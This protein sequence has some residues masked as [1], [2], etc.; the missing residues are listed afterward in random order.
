MASRHEAPS[1]T[2]QVK[3]HQSHQ[4]WKQGLV[5]YCTLQVIARQRNRKHSACCLATSQRVESSRK[6]V[7]AI[8]TQDPEPAA[9]GNRGGPVV[10]VGPCRPLQGRQL[11]KLHAA[12]SAMHNVKQARVSRQ[13]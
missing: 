6:D 3:C 9:V 2:T 4:V 12:C 11:V 7:T 1:L 8:T 5:W 13:Q 10:I